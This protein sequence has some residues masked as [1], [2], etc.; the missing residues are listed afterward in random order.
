MNRIRIVIIADSQTNIRLIAD[1]VGKTNDIEITETAPGLH[2]GIE[3]V[4]SQKPDIILVQDIP[5]IVE[6][7]SAIMLEYPEPGVIIMT[8][9]N[10]PVSANRVVAALACGAFD[11]VAIDKSETLCS[12]ILSKIRCCSIK[13]YSHIARMGDLDKKADKPHATDVTSGVIPDMLTKKTPSNTVKPKF[14]AVLIGVSTG[15]P[16]ALM[17]LLPDFPASFPV[18]IIIVLHMPKE[19]TG[20]M[21]AALDKKTNI[22]VKEAEDN[23]EPV[24]GTAYL[25]PGG[26][27][28]MLYNETNGKVRLRIKDGPAENGCKPAVDAL[29]RSAAPILGDKIAAIVLTGMG[30]DGTKGAKE[31]K[32]RGGVMLAQDENSST[33]WGMPGSIVRAGLADEVLPLDRIAARLCELI[34]V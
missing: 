30:V 22:R 32:Q 12:L 13:R 27:H 21:A 7:T 31:I 9:S 20:A 5:G 23:E 6:F 14:D 26:I 19:F 24:K 11:F 29:F 16:V 15:G 2:S 8:N 10:N 28:C 17:K 33:V 1:A 25:A 34:G 4:R 3:I 18:P